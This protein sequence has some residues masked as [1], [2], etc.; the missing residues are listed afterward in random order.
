MVHSFSNNA[1]KP[2][3]ASSAVPQHM[4]TLTMKALTPQ[5]RQD[6][7]T[8]NQ[9]HSIA[10]LHSSPIHFGQ[11]EGTLPS[12]KE[13]STLKKTRPFAEKAWFHFK[14]AA[15][16]SYRLVEEALNTLVSIGCRMALMSTFIIPMPKFVYNF[17]ERQTFYAPIK[18]CSLELLENDALADKIIEYKIPMKNGSNKRVNIAAWH[19]PAPKDS[20]KP[21]ILF[22][23]GR[24]SNISH[25]KHYLKAFS[26]EGYGILAYDYPGFGNS[27]GK[28]SLEN[29]YQSCRE[30][31]KYLSERIKEVPLE[32]QILMGYSLGTHITSHLAAAIHDNKNNEFEGKKPK[33][34]VLINSFPK[35]SDGVKHQKKQIAKNKLGLLNEKWVLN[36]LDYCF[37]TKRMKADLDTASN[38]EKATGLK[39]L[40]LSGT[41]DQELNYKDAE[42]MT[43][44]LQK[45][46]HAKIAF[47]KMEGVAHTLKEKDCQRL[48]Q[49]LA[50]HIK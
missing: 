18:S 34:V 1:H 47:E 31:S 32:R 11:Q 15:W 4:A 7:F 29:C 33:A 30:V 16:K 13:T 45:N 6:C 40:V 38:L 43:Q 9:H 22:S 21:T 36:G 27:T 20:D 5:A 19:I 46:G 10:P 48:I 39:T 23:H 37:D 2:F 25:L 35:L 42:A 8:A 24:H 49:L 41:A 17:I 14:E 12:G 50:K 26:D 44:T 3:P 28:V